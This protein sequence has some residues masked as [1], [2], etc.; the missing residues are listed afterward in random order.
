[1]LS[2]ILPK[3]FLDIA[4]SVSIM[5][6]I[7]IGVFILYKQQYTNLR[8]VVIY[9]FIYAVFE[10]I[11][12][13]HALNHLQNHF[14]FNILSYIDIIFWGVFYYSILEKT[15]TKKIVIF[16]VTVTLILTF[17]SHFGTGRDFNRMDSFAL[18]VGSI[19]LIAMSLLYFHQILNNL[20]IKNIFIYPFFWIN[21][22]VLI[23]FSGSFFSFIFAEY[24]AFSPEIGRA[25]V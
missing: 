12:W 21:V 4:A 13:Y 7:I 23:Y 9:C 5:A 24:I 18:S 15:V 2:N 3:Y 16:L 11:A 19:S 8:I 20:E 14:L 6:P 17:W 22:A 10:I 25:H 1:M